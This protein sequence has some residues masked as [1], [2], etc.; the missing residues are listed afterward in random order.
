[1][2]NR[3]NP[4]KPGIVFPY[5]KQRHLSLEPA[6]ENKNKRDYLR[7]AFTLG[8]TPLSDEEL[9]N[10]LELMQDTTFGVVTVYNNSYEDYSNHNSLSYF[11]YIKH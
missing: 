3:A 2:P 4:S 7:R 5:S 11:V 1:L 9:I 8:T 6:K 10:F